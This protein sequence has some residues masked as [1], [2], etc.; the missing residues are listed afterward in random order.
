MNC[1][2][3]N[4]SQ[5]L[6]IFTCPYVNVISNRF[7]VPTL[8]NLWRRHVAQS[9]SCPSC[10]SD[11]ED[12]IHAL[13]GYPALG[14]I[15]EADGLSKNLLKYK[16]SKLGTSLSWFSRILLVPTWT[17]LQWFSDWFGKRE[18]QIACGIALLAI[19]ISGPR[20]FGFFMISLL[21]RF[22]KNPIHPPCPLGESGGPLPSPHAT[23]WTTTERYSRKLGR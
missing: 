16:L 21:L 13:W 20:P 1:Y 6:Y 3:S 7:P 8:F 10:K 15:W 14:I 12:T 11:C 4:W 18:M 2:F 5:I 9:V 17:F 23:K 19:K 22:W